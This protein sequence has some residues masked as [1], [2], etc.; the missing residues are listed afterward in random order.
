MDILDG[1]VV[2][3]GS[4]AVYEPVM[5]RGILESEWDGGWDVSF[6]DDHGLKYE[7]VDRHEVLEWV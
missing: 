4:K 1:D 2:G 3:L 5:I 7:R 6:S